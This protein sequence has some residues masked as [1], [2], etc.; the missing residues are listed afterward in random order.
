MFKGRLLINYLKK[1][2]RNKMAGKKP[3]DEQYDEEEDEQYDEEEDEQYD[4]EEDE[5]Y[6][7]EEDEQEGE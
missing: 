2:N 1:L 5:Q 4:E 3:W 6:D 7:E